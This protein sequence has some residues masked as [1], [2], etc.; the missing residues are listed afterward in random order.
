MELRGVAWSCVEL[1]GL[2][3]VLVECCYVETK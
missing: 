1:C 2:R 3:W